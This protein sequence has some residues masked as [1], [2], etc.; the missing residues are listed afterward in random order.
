M[1]KEI[2]KHK[3]VLEAIRRVDIISELL[4]KHDGHFEHELDLEVIAYGRNYNG[5]KVGPYV[6]LLEY[7][8]GEEV[9]REGDWGGNTFYVT[10][11]GKLD[12]YVHDPESNENR[13]VGEIPSGVSFG[14]MSILAGVPRNATIS[15]APG[16]KAR[17]LEVTRP[18]LR[19]L[20]KLP[21]FGQ[22]LDANYR[23]HGLSRTLI[24]VR[25][26]TGEAFT[27]ELADKLGRSARFTVYAKHHVLFREGELI[28]RVIFIRNGWVRR[29]RGLGY[30]AVMGDLL[31]EAL[32]D[33]VGVDF[34]GAGN[35]L[36]LEGV[37]KDTRW[38]Y[39]AVVLQRT[40]VLEVAMPPLRSDRSLRDTVVR[41]F[42]DFSLADDDVLVSSGLD[43]EVIS[44]TEREIATGIVDGT[45]L[46]VMDM[47][48]C[49]RCGNCSMACH[50]VHGQSR[51]L[52][53][54]IHIGRVKNYG[55]VSSEQ[56]LVPSVCMHCQDPEC[57]TGCPTG[58]IGRFENGQIDIDP[59]TC[60]GCGDCATQCPYNAITMIP[61]K[62]EVAK[63]QTLARKMKGMLSMAPATPPQP[64]TATDNLLATKCNLCQGTTLNPPDAKT[65]SY[66][67]QE[68]CPTGALV[69]VNPREYFTEVNTRLGLVF[70]D[71]NQA[72]GRNI[73]KRDPLA[74]LWHALGLL[75]AVGVTAGVIWGL[76]RFGIDQR[77][78][79]T[80]L[81]IRW[82]TGLIGLGGIAA[83][84]TYPVRKQV[85]RRRA[86][87]LRYWM[88]M[89]VYLGTVAGLALLLH[90]GKTTGGL[91]TSLLMISFDAV[92]VTGLFGIIV[93]LIAPRIM[94]SIEGE[95]LLVEDLRARRE[96]L[97]E[98]LA[99]IGQRSNERLREFIRKKVRGKVFAFRYLLRQYLRR[100]ELT[101][102]LA[103]A[104]EEYETEARG[105]DPQSRQ[106]LLEAIEATVT[107]RRV[108]SLIYLHQLLKLWLAPHV[109][110]SSLMLA[111]MTVHVVQVIFFAAR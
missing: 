12:V 59:K 89:H 44:A 17:V 109:V 86:G 70:R 83:V 94:T 30:G 91:L 26:A 50:Q 6:H 22:M 35:C 95:P 93:Y 110:A 24:E 33:D 108:D 32:S 99:D 14:E 64:V 16:S 5:K 85:Y 107:L 96:E 104:R 72:I 43:K 27:Q 105:L 106:L 21:K 54:G 58:A 84:M 68:N 48:K 97:R 66:S 29:V 52:R 11:D 62:P 42:S 60:I 41:T 77:L 79:G 82:V 37:E 56:L 38:A 98:T 9:I 67:C 8:A 40:E 61:R 78:G 47:D 51:L 65:Q 7:D 34:L 92:I 101:E 80:W 49:V 10:V 25:Q 15:V 2:K 63:P 87:A 46:L 55:G 88:L 19:L 81:T 23:K 45:N 53:R 39:T 102:L 73:H 4:E 74:R 69:R 1:P 103:A 13:K 111:L 36:G 57:L 75:L 71:Q 76:E 31:V 18:A 28:D 90:G 3:T 20:R 100:E